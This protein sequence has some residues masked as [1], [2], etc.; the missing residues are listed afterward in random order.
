MQVT[1]TIRHGEASETIK[2]FALDQ[3]ERLARYFDRLVEADIILDHEVHG[4]RHI[5]EVRLHTSNDTHFASAEAGDFRT[6]VDLTMEKLRRQLTRH[7]EKLTGRPMT[8]VERERLFPLAAPAP[9]GE[10]E[11]VPAEWDRLSS[12]EA[13]ARLQATGEEVLVF[14]DNLD[15]AVKIARRNGAGVVDVVEAETFEPEDR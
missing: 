13:I 12:E 7:K 10:D 5:A 1:L 9:E 2:Q 6:A 11:P 15:G 14:L 4:D 8:K 3:V